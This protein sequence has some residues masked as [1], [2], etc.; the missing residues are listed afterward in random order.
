MDNYTVKP[1]GIIEYAYRNYGEV[2][3]KGVDI[4]LKSKLYKN[5]FFSGSLTFSNKYDEVED[6]E[7]ENVRNFYGK[8]N[9][10]YNL[11]AENYDLNLNLQS[12]YYGGKT[13]NLMNEMTHENQRIELSDFSLWKLTS[14][15]TFKSNYFMKIG[16]DNIFDFKD[17]SGGYNTGR[18]G[19]TFF[20]GLGIKI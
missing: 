5:L 9:L 2:M 6:R 17:E 3:L 4:L 18:P 20:V 19:R 16:L 1:G 15:H 8:F 12:N 14:T 7:F 13:I 10:D 11:D